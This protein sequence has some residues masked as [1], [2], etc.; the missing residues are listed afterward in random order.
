MEMYIGTRIFK[1]AEDMAK[2]MDNTSMLIPNV[3]E[4]YCGRNA[5]TH[6]FA[7]NINDAKRMAKEMDLKNFA[8]VSKSLYEKG[9]DY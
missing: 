2:D 1:N 9:R 6:F 7:E 5:L 4:A 8:K 3:Y